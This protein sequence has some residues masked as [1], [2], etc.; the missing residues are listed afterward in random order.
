MFKKIVFISLLMLL[1][2]CKSKKNDDKTKAPITPATIVDVVVAFTKS[3]DNTI[4]AN[5]TV[6]PNEQVEIH[7]EISGRLTYLNIPEGASV[8]AGTIL[9]KINDADLQA[10]LN[11]F[12]VQ[13]EL[14][15]KTEQRLK[16]LISING[17]NQADY[18]VAAN[19][20]NNL[21]ADIDITKAQID[22]TVIKAA[23]SGVLGLR[24]IS[25]GAYI[26]PQTSLATLQQISKTKIDF[27]LP[28]QY[29]HLI[30]KGKVINVVTN[31]NKTK[32]QAT[33]IATE[34][35]MNNTTRNLK[36]RAVLN[37]GNLQAGSFVKIKLQAGS[38][39]QSILIPTNAIIPDA[40]SKKLVV[41]KDGKGKYVSVETGIR[42]ANNVEITKGISIGDS[43]IVTGVLFVKPNSAV[44]VK[45]VLEIKE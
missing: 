21:K 19:T 30:E 4:E 5:G 14:A 12:K 32:L 11:K 26:T 24:N 40:D 45:K 8:A 18:D 9:A 37:D 39:N 17:I 1:F 31:Y 16:K 22:K 44:K 34:P 27:T 43:V 6:L 20:V 25:P 10:Q 42:S 2:S 28:E 36:V 3:I 35:E 38:N 23:F 7:P 15:I 13:L 33:I 29:T 41:I